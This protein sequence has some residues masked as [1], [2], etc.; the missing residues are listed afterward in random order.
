VIYIK[1]AVWM[2]LMEKELGRD[3]VDNAL[4]SYFTKW[5]FKH[6]SP[7]DFKKE[8][9]TISGKDLGKYFALLNKEGKLLFE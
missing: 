9:E 4:Q 2:F 8:L 6:P 3:V 5:R 7:E 1:T